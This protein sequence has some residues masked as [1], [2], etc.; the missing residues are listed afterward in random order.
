MA[1]D[2]IVA[3]LEVVA[4]AWDKT[5]GEYREAFLGAGKNAIAKADALKDVFAG[6]G[7]FIKSELANERI[8]VAVLTPSGSS[9]MMINCIFPD[10]PK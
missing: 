3:D 6:M 8:A 10:S 7:V 4:S 2:K 9:P 5:K 1:T